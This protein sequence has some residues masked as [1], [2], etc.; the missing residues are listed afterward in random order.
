MVMQ[1]LATAGA[2]L[3]FAFIETP[4]L[5]RSG[6]VNDRRVR[7]WLAYSERGR[8]PSPSRL[9][10]CYARDHRARFRADV[11]RDRG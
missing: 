6:D 1:Q 8:V 5:G 9:A 3:P 2:V 10:D 4:A 11:P 7:S